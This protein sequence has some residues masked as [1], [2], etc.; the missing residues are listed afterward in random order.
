LD[1]AGAMS[2]LTNYSDQPLVTII[3][4]VYN[5]EAYIT[6]AIYSVIH[7]S[8]THW[9]LL[10][11]DDGSTDNS[12]QIIEKFIS[13]K[14][15][16]FEQ[17]NRGVSVARNIGLTNMKGSFFCFLD[18]DDLLPSESIHVRVNH[19]RKNPNL[20]FVDG[21]VRVFQ[22]NSTVRYYYPRFTG[23]PLKALLRLSEECFFGPTWMIRREEG[24]KY[25]MFEGLTHGEDLLFYLEIS[26]RGG[27][28]GFVTY[29]VYSYRKHVQ[30]AMGNL[31]GLETGYWQ[32]FNII[33]TWPEFDFISRVT[34]QLKVRKFMFLDW[35]KR[36]DF[37][38]AL[39]ALLR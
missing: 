8:Y 11:I 29:N 25:Q 19:F 5:A 18:A 22:N 2:T 27:L 14:I 4:P 17:P 32:L 26:R 33:K 6:D 1:I 37:K 20:T 7:Q 39:L 36:K 10:I 16:C 30:S 35:I 28:Y 9:E 12:K 23:S 34:F 13:N 38:R 15:H 21:I 24:L 3:M 31:E